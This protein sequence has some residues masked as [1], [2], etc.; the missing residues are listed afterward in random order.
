MTNEKSSS[1]TRCQRRGTTVCPVQCI[2]CV[3]LQLRFGLYIF[4]SIQSGE[5]TARPLQP[6]S[7]IPATCLPHCAYCAFDT[8]LLEAEFLVLPECSAQQGVQLC[9]QYT[10]PRGVTPGHVPAKFTGAGTAAKVDARDRV[11][12]KGWILLSG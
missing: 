1:L 3:G 4:V 2:H 7:S 6:A 8:D 5:Q 11:V 12:R 10:N 9:P